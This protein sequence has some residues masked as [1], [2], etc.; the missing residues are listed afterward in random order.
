[1]V[2]NGG[3]EK[4]HMEILLVLPIVFN[5]VIKESIFYLVEAA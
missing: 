5:R 2:S 4:E 3:L 1:M